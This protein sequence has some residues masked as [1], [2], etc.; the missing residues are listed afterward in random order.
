MLM[1]MLLFW[2]GFM[3]KVR[4]LS[5][6]SLSF[7][8]ISK[9]TQKYNSDSREQDKHIHQVKMMSKLNRCSRFAAS[10]HL[11]LTEHISSLALATAESQRDVA[12]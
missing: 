1:F 3:Q 5:S 10:Y 12:L 6:G 8:F 9:K 7:F 2:S 11:N 4:F